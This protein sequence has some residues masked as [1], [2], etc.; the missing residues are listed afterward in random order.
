MLQH[1]LKQENTQEWN[2]TENKWNKNS[3]KL[4]KNKTF[5]FLNLIVSLKLLAEQS[6]VIQKDGMHLHW[7][8]HQ[9][10]V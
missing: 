8:P 10:L 9:A 5:F 3:Q 4:R 2:K 7:K 6:Q 1:V